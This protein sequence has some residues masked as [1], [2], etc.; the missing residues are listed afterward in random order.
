[1]AEKKNEILEEQRKARQEFLRLKKMQQGEIDAGPKPSEMAK[2]LKTP[3]EK[4]SHFWNYNKWFVIAG[5][6]SALFIAV[7]VAQCV[8]RTEYDLKL[9]YFTYTPV[10]DNQLSSV[11]DYIEEFTPDVNKDGE[12]N[13]QVVNCSINENSDNI[14]YN[15]SIYTKIQTM[16]A[17]EPSAMLYITDEKSISYFDVLSDDGG[18]FL[19]NSTTLLGK[20]FYT[21]TKTEGFGE[22]Y[23][24]LS[25][26]CRKIDNTL[27]E[28]NEEAKFYYEAAKK[29][30]KKINEKQK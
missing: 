21:K 3:K 17:V 30:I 20:D 5:I 28:E 19:E 6:I 13:V 2:T 23:E 8:T 1:M 27:L 18:D 29:V 14:T 25:I 15:N 9:V 24:G 16:V 22:L 11:A 26:S 4:F 10:L 7:I 12:V